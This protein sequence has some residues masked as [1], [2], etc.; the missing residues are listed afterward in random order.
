MRYFDKL[1]EWNF[2]F[3]RIAFFTVDLGDTETNSNAVS[4]TRRNAVSEINSNAVSEINSDAVS[5]M[6]AIFHPSGLSIIFKILV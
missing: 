5:G 6:Q 1:T 4:E 2:I 3:N